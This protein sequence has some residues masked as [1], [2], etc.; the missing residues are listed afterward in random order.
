M[1]ASSPPGTTSYLLPSS[2]SRGPRRRRGSAGRP[3]PWC[4]LRGR[5]ARSPADL[6][7]TRARQDARILAWFDSNGRGKAI[8]GIQPVSARWRRSV[9]QRLAHR[10]PYNAVLRVKHPLDSCNRI[11]VFGY[12]KPCGLRPPA[13]WI[14]VGKHYA[15]TVANKSSFSNALRIRTEIHNGLVLEAW[16]RQ[17]GWF[18]PTPRIPSKIEPP[19]PQGPAGCLSS[20]AEGDYL[21]SLT[22]VESA[23]M[24][25]TIPPWQSVACQALLVELNV[26]MPTYSSSIPF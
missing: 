1:F 11:S 10:A 12:P 18:P 15:H 13:I 17:G 14:L 4:R 8:R 20:G 26:R 19:W 7:Q 6:A 22:S 21:E 3:W 5:G 9:P 16:D 23:G 25:R 2:G 24:L